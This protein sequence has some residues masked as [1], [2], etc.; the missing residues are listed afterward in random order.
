MY[1]N[2]ILLSPSTN[3]CSHTTSKLEKF[4]QRNPHQLR[5]EFPA[6]TA[7]LGNCKCIMFQHLQS[8]SPQFSSTVLYSLVPYLLLHMHT[9]PLDLPTYLPSV[10]V[11]PHSLNLTLEELLSTFQESCS[12]LCR[13]LQ[14][15]NSGVGGGSVTAP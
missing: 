7:L 2:H 3:I 13:T 14:L 12:V 4:S 8:R 11:Q 15:S 5:D 6:L 1:L 10:A 9:P